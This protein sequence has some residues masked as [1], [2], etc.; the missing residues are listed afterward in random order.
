MSQYN[1]KNIKLRDF[2]NST[3]LN[4]SSAAWQKICYSSMFSMC[5]ILFPA[6]CVCIMGGANVIMPF[7]CHFLGGQPWKK[8][9]TPPAAK[10]IFDRFLMISIQHGGVGEVGG[11]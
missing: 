1:K 4:K 2:W 7:G 9:Q 8:R 5:S 11:R 10:C 3:I 6:A